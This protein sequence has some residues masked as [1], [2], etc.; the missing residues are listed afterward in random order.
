MA[1]QK[2]GL[3]ETKYDAL[4]YKVNGFAMQVH[5]ELKPG[6]KEKL[7]QRRLA[8]LCRA[9][10]LE[11]NPEQRVEVWVSDML[12]GYM[13]LDL[14]IEN[15]LVVECKALSHQLTNDEVYQ[16]VSYLAATGTDV[17]MIYNFG[18]SRLD[19]H[20]I[21]PPSQIRNWQKS[22]YRA[23]WVKPGLAL[24]PLDTEET[25]SPIRFV[26]QGT[27]RIIENPIRASISQSVE[28][29]R[30][31]VPNPLSISLDYASSGV[32]I[33]AGNRAVALMKDAVTSTYTSSVLAG[34]GSFGGLFDASALKEMNSPVLVASTDG[35]GT[36][37]KLA[38]HMGR[39]C[40]I[41]HDIVNHCI[42]DILVQGARPL[43]FMDY[44]ATSKLNP[45]QTAEVVTG[46]AEACKES[47]MPLLGGE[48]AEMPGVYQPNEFDVAGTIVGVVERDEI[49]PRPNL[50]AGDVLIGL[51][52][53]GPHTNGYSLIRKIF[54]ETPLDTFFPEFNS[55][56]ADALLTPHRSYY[57]ILYP[58]LPHIKALVHITGG[59]FLENIPRILPENLDAKIQTDS[60]TIPPL[61]NLIQQEGRIDPTE[62]YRVF[63]MGIG[64]IAFVDPLSVDKVQN[65]IPEETFVIGELVKGEKKV[66]LIK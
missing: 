23:I 5:N 34:I 2:P 22:L 17:G 35:V 12:V 64:M 56:L 65:S 47:G 4:T 51:K 21:F 61:W 57:S 15:Q 52:S 10:G 13:F 9:D 20:R 8:E 6:H 58:H 28:T 7:Y 19:Y 11:V 3:V 60:W 32:D 30:S 55:T 14:W 62:M 45:E 49:L 38:A 27:D 48:T 42:N 25:V 26:V 43:F 54:A 37:V 66:Q 50:K 40:G 36:K 1:K 24:P 39:F 46:I 18:R 59:G 33:D 41:G 63:N 53:S 16:A 29:I 44:F 31:S